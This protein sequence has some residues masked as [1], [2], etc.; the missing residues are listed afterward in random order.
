MEY[1]KVPINTMPT[2]IRVLGAQTL[3]GVGRPRLFGFGLGEL[4][5]NLLLRR[6]WREAPGTILGRLA[7]RRHGLKGEAIVWTCRGGFE[8][9]ASEGEKDCTEFGILGLNH[10]RF[11]QARGI[12]E[13]KSVWRIPEEEEK[14]RGKRR[15]SERKS[16]LC[17]T[18]ILCILA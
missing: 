11:I 4:E 16:L 5:Y 14:R 1:I 12:D 8:N 3:M 9:R 13:F 15:E 17:Q 10:E 7:S 6:I 18:I 2:A